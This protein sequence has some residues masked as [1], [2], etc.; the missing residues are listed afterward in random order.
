MHYPPE[1]YPHALEYTSE[2]LRN[3][4]QRFERNVLASLKGGVVT[5]KKTSVHF[6][7]PSTFPTK[8]PNGVFLISP[9][10]SKGATGK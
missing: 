3:D 2:E 10:P 1:Q 5:N 4:K 7:H 6:P 8:I 9:P